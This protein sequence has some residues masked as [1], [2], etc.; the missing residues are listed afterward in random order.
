MLG[1]KVLESVILAVPKGSIG[2]DSGIWFIMER[3]VL[4]RRVGNQE[5]FQRLGFTCSRKGR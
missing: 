3:K 2:L 1:I 4:P 5:D